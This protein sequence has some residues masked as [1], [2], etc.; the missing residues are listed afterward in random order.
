MGIVNLHITDLKKLCVAHNVET[1]YM[2][3]SALNPKFNNNS[4]IDLLVKFKTI[5]LANYFDNYMDLKV[6]LE[7]LLGRKIDLLEEQTLKN[8]ILIHSI[9]KS[10]ALIYG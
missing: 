8:P 7:K 2:F 10:K 9:N 5:E 3:G 4:D 6:N 1:M